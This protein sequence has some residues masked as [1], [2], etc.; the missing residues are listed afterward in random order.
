M[1]DPFADGTLIH[2]QLCFTGTAQT[3]AACRA[4]A[5]AAATCLSLQM[6][7]LT[8]EARQIV[9]ILGQFHLQH[10]FAGMGM[11]RKDIED[12]RGA[13]QNTDISS[14]VLPAIRVDGA[15]KFI[16]EDHHL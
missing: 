2:F 4:G 16:V 10:A 3:N 7:P 8:G 11:L 5:S 6:C 9:F 12:E 15:G 14:Q 1:R 13:V